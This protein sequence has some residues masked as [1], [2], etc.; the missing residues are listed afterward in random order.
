[1]KRD[2]NTISLWQHGIPSYQAS[3]QNFPS[4]AEV[5]IVG[6]GITGLSTAL[7]IQQSGRS[8]VLVEAKEIGF[9]TTGGTTAHINTILDTP[10]YQIKNHFGEENARKVAKLTRETIDL[11]EKNVSKYNIDCGFSRKSAFLYSQDREQS[12]ELNKIINSTNQAG[13]EI[14][15]APTLPI[16]IPFDTVAVA[17]GQAQIHPGRYLMA[18]AKEFEKAGG[19][20]VENCR[21]K[22][23]TS[24]NNAT[25][26]STTKGKI[27][28][29]HVV[30]ATH[31]PPGV[32]ILHFRC[33]PY[34]SYAMAVTLQDE[35][36]PDALI[37][38][39][40]SPY[41][42]FRSQESDGMK[43]LIVGGEDHKSGHAANTEYSFIKL[44]SYIR[45]YFAVKEV[46]FQWSS[47]FFESVDGLPYIGHLPGNPENIYVA[48]GFGGN[49]ITYGIASSIILSELITT[50]KSEYQELFNP[51]RVKLMAGFENLVKE[52]SDVIGVFIGRRLSIKEIEDAVELSK[53]EAR[54]VK[55]EGISLAIY[56]DEN[57][58]L[59]ALNPSC[60]HTKCIVAWNSSEKSWDCPCHGSRF[61]FTGEVLNTPA[62]KNLVKIDLS[63]LDNK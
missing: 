29:V 59:F 40:Y 63:H 57:G 49:G 16:P 45:K 34:R 2:G 50:G 1:M 13:I 61:S 8:C 12:S 43:Y 4:Q 33:A 38:D 26:V 54:V 7:K 36:Y 10:Y 9:G 41:H 35:N 46:A 55:Y 17:E 21:M 30:Y 31:I 58:E 60:P 18:I 32:N 3:T 62:T 37:Y 14:K 27:A 19:I 51:N 44:E 42:Y 5:V 20:I 24:E 28:A 22:E 53:G 6:A 15:F 47:Q 39:L 52:A 11:V 48:T 25:I 56:K 23:V